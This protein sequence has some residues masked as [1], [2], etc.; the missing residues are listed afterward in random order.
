MATFSANTLG[1][2]WH[3][4]AP[5]P[6]RN[7]NTKDARNSLF[8]IV[9]WQFSSKAEP[10]LQARRSPVHPSQKSA[11]WLLHQESNRRNQWLGSQ[12][13]LESNLVAGAK[14]PAEALPCSLRSDIRSVSMHGGNIVRCLSAAHAFQRAKGLGCD[15]L[16]RKARALASFEVFKRG[17]AKT[18]HKR[19]HN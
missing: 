8:Q 15:G 9:E 16:V 4:S 12:H 19:V 18:S 6:P 17:N 2:L 14:L 3:K 7:Q 11:H 13:V 10:F 1:S 5:V